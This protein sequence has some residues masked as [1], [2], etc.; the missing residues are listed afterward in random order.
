MS[1]TDL[2]SLSPEEQQIR[3]DEP[4]ISPPP[5]VDASLDDPPNGNDLTRAVVGVAL[6]ICSFFVLVHIFGS[7]SSSRKLRINDSYSYF[8]LDST[9][10]VGYLLHQWDIRMKDMIYLIR[11]FTI[12][13]DLFAFSALTIKTAIILEWLRIFNPTGVRN[14]F[15]WISYAVLALNFIFHV[16]A[17]VVFNVACKPY[18]KNWNP[19]IPGSCYDTTSIYVA[20][21]AI[22]LVV[23][24]CILLLPQKAIWGLQMPTKKKLGVAGMFMVGIL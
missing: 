17:F 5:G 13:S 18:E 8:V 7:W 24:V 14:G 23:D 6:A 4:T 21:T 11:N 19:F 2:S 10:K 16:T 22:Y 20:S 15:Y 12:G 1:Q 9:D 3:L